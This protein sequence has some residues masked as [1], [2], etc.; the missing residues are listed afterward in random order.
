MVKVDTPL[1]GQATLSINSAGTI[2]VLPQILRGTANHEKRS[3]FSYNRLLSELV[4]PNDYPSLIE[5]D[6]VP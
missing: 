3:L 1:S 4:E 2:C 6:F 5:R